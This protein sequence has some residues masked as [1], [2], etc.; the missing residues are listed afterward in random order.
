MNKTTNKFST[1]VRADGEFSANPLTQTTHNYAAYILLT[2]YSYW[3]HMFLLC[4]L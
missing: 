2:I 3:V 1:E 4:S